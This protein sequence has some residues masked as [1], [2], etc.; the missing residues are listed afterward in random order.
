MVTTTLT[1]L[2]AFSHQRVLTIVMATILAMITNAGMFLI[3]FRVL[4]PG[5]IRL[6]QLLPG[7]IAGGIIWTAL[8][9]VGTIL[10][11]HALHGAAVYGVFATVLGLLAWVYLGAE[12]A[13]YAAEL[14]V[15]V[16]RRLWP[17]A[18]VQPPLTEADR[19]SMALQALQNQR[20]EEQQ[21]RV[22]FNDRPPGV[23]RA[24]TTPRTPEDIL[25]P[26]VDSAAPRR[27]PPRGLAPAAP[28]PKSPAATAVT[29]RL[30]IMLMDVPLVSRGRHL[31][32]IPAPRSLAG[33]GWRACGRGWR[34]G[35]CPGGGSGAGRAGEAGRGCPAG[36]A[37]TQARDHRV[38]SPYARP[39][40]T[41]G[42][43][44]LAAGRVGASG[45]ATPGPAARR[46]APGP[47]ARG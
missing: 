24:A 39:Q 15:V 21:I 36:Y 26:D 16:A 10:V 18:M 29:A 41:A 45:A 28:A 6:R 47:R 20:R 13:V 7:S 19:H 44:G 17:R 37:G 27:R 33:A 11:R 42:R 30:M 40:V 3:G 23:R 25:H 22:T 8:Q 5:S 14:N 46:S 38:I 43:M 31:R 4:T 32:N 35:W 12:V 34:G 2:E 1:G 9:T